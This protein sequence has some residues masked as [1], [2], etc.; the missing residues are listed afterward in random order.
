MR[1]PHAVGKT[2]PRINAVCNHV[3][4]E[5]FGKSEAA[6]RLL[7]ATP[8]DATAADVCGTEED[9][10]QKRAAEAAEHEAQQD[11]RRQDLLELYELVRGSCGISCA[12][13]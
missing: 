6:E 10:R 4:R 9:D 13:S 8:P 3:D 12:S 11:K 2:E 5:M 1:G 7:H